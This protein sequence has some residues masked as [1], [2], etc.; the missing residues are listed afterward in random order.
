MSNEDLKGGGWQ[1]WSKHVLLELE[2]L[3][4]Q[5]DTILKA[6]NE[7]KQGYVTNEEYGKLK[8]DFTSTKMDFET[9]K[10]TQRL[11]NGMISALTSSVM[12]I[13]VGLAVA[14]LSK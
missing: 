14:W 6:V 13:I 7:I 10:A 12:A 1:E 8:E 9:F 5:S 4:G 3:N 11:R 2:R